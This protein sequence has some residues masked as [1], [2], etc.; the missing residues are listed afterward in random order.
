M[1]RL[2]LLALEKLGRKKVLLD[3]HGSLLGERW[4][5]LYKEDDEDKRWIARLPN[6]YIHRPRVLDSPDGDTQHRHPWPTW[7]LM[8]RGGY[9]E[10]VN[11]VM[12]RL[13]TRWSWARLRHTDYHRIL[14]FEPGTWTMFFHG[15][16]RASWTFKTMPCR[17][18]CSRCQEHYGQCV[19][20]ITEQPHGA[21]FDT[22][23]SWRKT[24]WIDA[25]RPGLVDQ[26]RRRQV[27]VHRVRV[28]TPEQMRERT[29]DQHLGQR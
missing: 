16:R 9:L 6:I 4:Y 2:I 20:R 1:W 12:A 11:G 15:F 26:I 24:A 22:A 13:H 14:R 29:L 18:V 19:N 21:H 7:S 17:T 5:V 23:H 27:A 28:L 10:E 25:D 8:L 3:F